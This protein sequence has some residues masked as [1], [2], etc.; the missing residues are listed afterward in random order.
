MGSPC[1]RETPPPILLGASVPHVSVT[2]PLPFF[3]AQDVVKK[4]EK[5]GR[6]VEVRIVRGPDG[7]SRGFGFVEMETPEDA[8]EVIRHLDRAEWNGRKLLCEVAKNP[9]WVRSPPS[10]PA[11]C[12]CFMRQPPQ[13][14]NDSRTRA[15]V[16]TADLFVSVQVEAGAAKAGAVG[17]EDSRRP[18]F[19][20]Y[21]LMTR[22]PSRLL[23]SFCYCHS[24]TVIVPS[25]VP[26]HSAQYY[27]ALKL[28]LAS[29]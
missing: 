5:Y 1:F 2:P 9:R 4:F 24:V 29:S 20:Q 21:V 12:E 13:G 23:L 6:V 7:N 27:C 28:P 8:K 14:L 26:K 18:F 10:L 11:V 3:W 22:W 25:V 17:E 19:A 16:L 15:C